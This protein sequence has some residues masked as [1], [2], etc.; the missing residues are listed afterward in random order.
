MLDVDQRTQKNYQ[1]SLSEWAYRSLGLPGVRLRI[2]LQGNNLHILCESRECP[3]AIAVVPQFVRAL[4][5][6]NGADQFPTDPGRPIDK[7]ILYGRAID[8]QRPDWFEA[9]DLL[10]LGKEVLEDEERRN[11]PLVRNATFPLQN[12]QHHLSL[13]QHSQPE[14]IARSLSKEL[15]NLGIRCKVSNYNLGDGSKSPK[16]DEGSRRLWIVCDADDKIEE[17]LL[18]ESM[19]MQ[20]RQMNLEGFR[21][22]VIRLSIRGEAQPDG[23]LRIDL[24][25]KE[26]MLKDW[27]RWGDVQAIARLLNQTLA[28]KQ[29]S[30]QVALE[31]LTLHLFCS[32]LPQANKGG[33]IPN[34]ETVVNAIAPLL[35]S[36]TPQG[37]QFTS[38]YGVL[39]I[40]QPLPE[41]SSAAWIESLNL[42]ASMHPALAPTPLALAQ[43]GDRD[44][45]LF[46]LQ[47]LLNPDLDRRLA[48][49]GIRLSLRNKQD[50]LHIMSEAPICPSQSQVGPPI[51]RFIR[52]MG[53][54]DIAGVRVYGRRAGQSS[55]LWSYGI[56]FVKRSRRVSESMPDFVNADV[57]SLQVAS[58][59]LIKRHPETFKNSLRRTIEGVWS[60]SM[61]CLCYS[62]LLIPATQRKDL[63]GF[64]RSQSKEITSAQAVKV[65]CVWGTLGL[66]LTIQADWLM[67][68]VLRSTPIPDIA[69]ISMSGISSNKGDSSI[70]FD[71]VPVGVNPQM[72]WEQP[73]GEKTTVFNASGFTRTGE[74]NENGSQTN[75]AKPAIATGRSHNPSFNNPL[76]DEKLV[77]YQQLCSKYG[78]PD[79]LIVGSSRAMRGIDP[80]ALQNALADRGYRDIK[81]FNFGVNGATAQVVDLLVRRLL[82]PEQLPKMIIWGDGARAFNSGRADNTYNAIAGSPAYQQLS[83]GTWPSSSRSQTSRTSQKSVFSMIPSYETANSWLNQT[84]AKASATY[85]QRDRLQTFLRQ[86]YAAWL[87]PVKEIP[88][89]ASSTAEENSAIE[90]GIDLN[91]FLPLSIRF[92]PLTYYQEH[93]KVSGDYD[94]DYD[95]FQLAGQQDNASE[96]LLKFV[97]AHQIALVFV[98]LPLTG[99]YLDPVRKQYEANFTLHM[100]Q[101]QLENK[102]IFVNLAELW[103]TRNDYFSDPSHLNRYGAFEVSNQLAQNQMIPWFS[104]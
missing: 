73:S 38:I 102:L 94:N 70:N 71:A 60:R 35:E 4:K 83:A 44:A 19:A 69:T 56:D 9:I 47:R 64:P 98:N 57:S 103:P 39:A 66:L 75:S 68:Y 88:L 63:E 12:L 78:P 62:Q 79:V 104:K 76:L 1:Y 40:A 65:A 29:I 85:S 84:L 33:A 87:T 77:I 3:D 50:L 45:L 46:L 23:V 42:P 8:R 61:Q 74:T 59:A 97:Q 86:Q 27:A 54:P 52:Q 95:S 53:I 18:A 92:D 6:R 93:P 34:Q 10:Q 20:L 72:S 41:P 80:A 13:E 43:Q 96:E 81:I 100:Q 67:S 89:T 11:D 91:G 26:E 14:A 7:L 58:A 24:T 16:A 37:I 36:L 2:R 31:D 17:S 51:A 48:T 21:D 55:P 32:F 5:T 22:A 25:P 90:A 99:Q 30:S 15:N 82:T 49:G 101:Q 28:A